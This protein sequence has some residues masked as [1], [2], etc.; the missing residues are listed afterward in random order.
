M[1]KK[2]MRALLGT[3]L[4]LATVF[5]TISIEPKME[6]HAAAPQTYNRRELTV[7]QVLHPGDVIMFDDDTLFEPY[8]C[9]SNGGL[10]DTERVAAGQSRILDQISVEGYDCWIVTENKNKEIING[11]FGN[12]N[13]ILEIKIAKYTDTITVPCLEL[14]DT[15]I[16]VNGDIKITLPKKIYER[17]KPISYDSYG[18]YQLGDGFLIYRGK[19]N[20]DVKDLYPDYESPGYEFDEIIIYS[21]YQVSLPYCEVEQLDI[22]MAIKKPEGMSK[23]KVY[24]YSTTSNKFEYV[25]LFENEDITVDCGV[26][27]TDVTIDSSSGEK[28]YNLIGRGSFI[29]FLEMKDYSFKQESLNQTYTLDKDDTLT[30]TADVD[31]AKFESVAVDGQI[32]S[33]DKYTAKSGSTIVELKKDYLNTLSAGEHTVTVNWV[34]GSASTKI[35]VANKSSVT[36]TE[37]STTEATTENKVDNSVKTGDSFKME[38]VLLFVIAAAGLMVLSI[39]KKEK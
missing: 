33:A 24:K 35:K 25:G 2:F 18:N 12:T 5:G 34:D 13:K 3:A 6:T 36:T 37:A 11:P 21:Y 15:D 20:A 30:L 31:F 19:K 27:G 10:P 29:A 1:K 22:K 23:V 9:V 17:K 28:Y 7:G 16:K 14:S 32:I 38:V 4:A 8:N 39:R 26:S